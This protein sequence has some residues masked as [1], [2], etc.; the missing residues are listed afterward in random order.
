[1]N[2]NNN[3]NSNKESRLLVS[4]CV[5]WNEIDSERSLYVYI[6]WETLISSAGHELKK[7]KRETI[8][9]VKLSK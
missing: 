5:E 2:D 6:D 3:Q 1:M 4:L 9:Y 8:V 7:R